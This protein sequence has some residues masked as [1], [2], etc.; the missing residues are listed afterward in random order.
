MDFFYSHARTALKF[1]LLGLGF[2]PGDEILL[3]SF[4]CDVLLHPLADLNVTPIFYPVPDLTPDFNL[5][6]T[7]IGKKTRGFLFV[8]YFGHSQGSIE[9]AVR[10]CGENNLYL[11][12]DNAHGFGASWNGRPLGSFGDIGIC[13]PRKSLGWRNGGIL[14]WNHNSEFLPAYK[15]P[16]EP[17]RR[18]WLTK[19]PL[20]MLSAAMP[21]LRNLSRKM[22]DYMSFE[23][24][25]EFPIASWRMDAEYV[26]ALET[27]SR[28]EIAYQRKNIW[29]IWKRWCETTDL[30]PIFRKI[31]LGASP[32]AFVARTRSPEESQN[33]YSWGW[34]NG[35]RV[36]SWP[37]LPESVIKSDPQTV[38]LRQALVCF[39]ID[40]TMQETTLE[41]R[42][43]LAK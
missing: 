7:L 23:I 36:Y 28:A 32:L 9:E 40:S 31:D 19:L 14:H 20:R 15:L 43:G 6:R 10:F 11:I 12:E 27:L 41:K 3:P 38:R 5:V 35:F 13:S 17:G 21:K 33:W 2:K 39:S 25:R 24:G 18:T 1:G 26:R 37:T 42:L 29:K 8:H 22:P 30:R 16:V 4:I 34:R